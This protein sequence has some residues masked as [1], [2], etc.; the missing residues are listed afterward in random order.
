MSRSEIERA[1]CRAL[2]VCGGV[3]VALA[4]CSK[5]AR[6]TTRLPAVAGAGVSIE[7]LDNVLGQVVLGTFVSYLA[8]ALVGSKHPLILMLG[9]AANVSCTGEFDRLIASMASK[10][11]DRAWLAVH[12]NHDS[13]MSG[14]LSVY[15]RASEWQRDWPKDR[16]W[17]V[18]GA[19]ESIRWGVPRGRSRR[20]ARPGRRRSRPAQRRQ[21]GARGRVA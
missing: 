19:G 1:L 8:G 3:L 17:A 10:G 16:M 11:G 18:R 2:I 7:R 4:G 13:F 6:L 15:Q 14:N 20:S 21:A 5:V 12:G 9:D